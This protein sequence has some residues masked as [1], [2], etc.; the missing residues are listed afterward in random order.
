MQPFFKKEQGNNSYDE[1]V[2]NE[3]AIRENNADIEKKKREIL[4]IRE[5][6]EEI[7]RERGTLG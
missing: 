1:I 3:K 2:R 6:F 4:E 5:R 7:E